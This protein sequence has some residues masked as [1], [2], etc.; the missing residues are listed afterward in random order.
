MKH[1]AV[2]VLAVVVTACSSQPTRT[3]IVPTNLVVYGNW[4]GFD[5]PR[6]PSTAPAPIDELDASCMR[7]DYCY[8]DKGQFACDCDKV[9]N[10]E[11]QT[12]LSANRYQGYQKHFALS[13]HRYFDASPC[14][15]T[16]EG[17]VGPSKVLQTIYK[18]VTK[19][20][21]GLY[22][23]IMGNPTDAPAQ[24]GPPESD[25]AKQEGADKK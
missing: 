20:A 10:D 23:H 9:F 19:K 7:H 2:V 1:V 16:A 12:G 6:D 21:V 15:G 17:K 25:P 5:H 11:L 24:N 3:S 8:V 13:F 14:A 18:D 4:C 22:D